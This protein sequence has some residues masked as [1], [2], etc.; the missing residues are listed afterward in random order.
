MR[1][2]A[3]RRCLAA[4]AGVLAALL[5][6]ACA[7]GPRAQRALAGSSPAAWRSALAARG[8]SVP[9][10]PNPIAATPE[11][12]E[13]ALSL[14]ASGTPRERLQAL[15]RALFDPSRFPFR[16]ESR[17]TR[18]AAQ[19]FAMR[20][21]NCL[22]FTCLFIAMARSIGLDVRA[23]VPTLEG[24]AER[25]GDLVVVNTHVVAACWLADG[26]AI[27]DF[28][29]TRER[30]VVGA[31]LVDDL[32]LAA[33]YENNLGVEEL[34]G[35]RYVDAIR[36]FEA[37]VRLS[38]ALLASR[39]NLGVARR[40]AGDVAG[41]LEAYQ[42][43]LEISPRDPVVLGNLAALYRAQ[44]R[45][46]EA[47]VALSLASLDDASAFFLVVRAD[48][49]R[50][51]GRTGRALRLYRRARHLDPGAAEPWVGIGESR[52]ERGDLSGARKAA[53]KARVLDP[54]SEGA[55]DLLRRIGAAP[56]AGS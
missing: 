4:T 33:L 42:A 41:A 7:A 37:S 31:Q 47:R 44:G 51:Q 39:G 2:N 20:E 6:G 28:D 34:R 9:A 38:P 12:R 21:G 3:A 5:A 10:I 11:M 29:R 43:A 35:G 17:G 24:E 32:H 18:T 27:F 36:R 19:A 13:E 56:R 8:L 50:V 25:D 22:S 54:A 14:A 53:E 40:R 1:E 26:F 15:Q 48:L 16:Y 49:E 30:R 55:A 52:L 23:A 45:E 46:R